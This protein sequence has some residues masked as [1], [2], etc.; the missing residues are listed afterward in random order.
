MPKYIKKTTVV[1][2]FQAGAISDWGDLGNL[3]STDYIIQLAD[4]TFRTMDKTTFENLYEQTSDAAILI[5]TVD[6]D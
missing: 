6:W 3:T 1:Y 2:A 4:S 5:G